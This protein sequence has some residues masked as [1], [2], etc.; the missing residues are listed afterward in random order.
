MGGSSNKHDLTRKSG[1]MRKRGLM[2]G[3]K[4]VGVGGGGAELQGWNGGFP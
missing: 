3:N 1:E 2:Q 4:P